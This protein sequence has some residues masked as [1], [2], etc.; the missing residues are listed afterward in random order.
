M[1]EP[2]TAV[3][4]EQLDPMW[5]LDSIHEGT[6]DHRAMGFSSAYMY[7]FASTQ[8]P[9]GG[10]SLSSATSKETPPWFHPFFSLRAQLLFA[11]SVLLAFI[12]LVVA[13]LIYMRSSH[14]YVVFVVVALVLLG[15]LAAYAITTVLLRPLYRAIDASQAIALGDL[16]QRKRLSLHLP[17]QDDIDR[18]AGSLDTMVSHLEKVEEMQRASELRFKQFFSDASHQLRTP[19]TSIRGF[20][21]ILMRGAI[22]DVKTRQHV[23]SRMK[24]ESERMTTLIN[25]LLTLARLDDSHPL[26]LQYVDMLELA[27]SA[28]AQAKSLATD[29]RKITLSLDTTDRL[30]AQVDAERIKQVLFILLD[31]ALKYG[32]PAPDGEII[33]RLD[34]RYRQIMI[35]VIDNGEGIAEEDLAHIFESFYRGRQHHSASQPTVVGAGL[36]LTIAHAIVRAHNGSIIVHSEAGKGT[37]FTVFLPAVE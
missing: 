5:L 32:R 28:L 14:L 27:S 8:A 15:S 24:S 17:P 30:G 29:A 34:K 3:T 36:G 2:R 31:N 4:K 13:L 33:M 6:V 21:E 20:T 26:K 12:V 18:L 37:T 16:A 23:L 1:S 25:D 19:L 35:Q 11:Y 10:A 9:Q 22:D 7:P